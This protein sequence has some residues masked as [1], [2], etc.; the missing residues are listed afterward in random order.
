M[1]LASPRSRSRAGIANH[2]LAKRS[3]FQLMSSRRVWWTNRAALWLIAALFF[4]HLPLV[5]G[6]TLQR[7]SV[8]ARPVRT[9][10]GVGA[11]GAS[12]PSA[13]WQACTE[14]HQSTY[15]TAV[16]TEHAHA[17]D[18]I[19]AQG[20]QDNSACNRCHTTQGFVNLSVTPQ[21]VGVQCESCHGA[22]A[23][24][25]ANPGDPIVTPVVTASAS[26]CGT[27][28]TGAQQ[29]TF[30]EWQTSAHATVTEAN[31]NSSACGRCHLG[32][33]RLAM[34]TKQSAL[35]AD[36]STA[37]TCPVCHD[38]H[39][40]HVYKNPLNGTINFTNILTG[41]VVVIDNSDLGA[42][43]T[44][45]LR[46]PLAS[47][48]D[49]SLSPT[50]AFPGKYDA[51]I[52]V[53][54]QCH[55]RRGAAWSDTSS[56]PH[57]SPQYNV[58]LGTVGELPTGAKPGFP[59]TH[60]RLEKQCAGCHMPDVAHA[61]P[62]NLP[63]L[64]SHTFTVRS[65]DLCAQ[66]HRDAENAANLVT[67]VQQLITS[68]IAVIQSGLDEWATSKAPPA[69]RAKYGTRA[70]EYTTPGELSPGGPGP[71][72][73]EQAL[74]PDNIKKARFNLYI[75]LQDGSYGVHNGPLATTLLDAAYEW[76]QAELN[77]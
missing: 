13:G 4:L 3:N 30:D 36:H 14:C 32:A 26:V 76:V 64:A 68:E 18:S 40:T 7:R 55:N 47:T 52:N 60:S 72:K 31:L 58:L 53:C 70:W 75:V 20:G 37:V 67:N 27:C 50:D 69:L 41:A 24:H 6:Q 46:N 63:P 11:V 35:Q 56:A 1:S 51:G 12:G 9:K 42:S 28:H 19:A 74:I 29:P 48:K 5:S 77:P 43:Y 73:A 8:A 33:A 65:Y 59:A 57:K 45:Q 44:A 61:G 16:R 10:S 66:C 2:E 22:A 25:A 49:Y 62:P 71:T 38:P 21:L 23:N 54:A 34:L 15:S 39:A 17:F